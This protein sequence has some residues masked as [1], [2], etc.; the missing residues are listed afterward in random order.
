[1]L[2]VNGPHEIVHV[3]VAQHRSMQQIKQRRARGTCGNIRFRVTPLHIGLPIPGSGRTRIALHG[4]AGQ[5]QLFRRL[6]VFM[7][8][9][10]GDQ[11]AA[12]SVKGNA[13]A[14]RR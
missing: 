5:L 13:A 2:L 8:A 11:G 7:T 6:W 3:V 4:N 9:P 12:V 1:M 10:V 14:C